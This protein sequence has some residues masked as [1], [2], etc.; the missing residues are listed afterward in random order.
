M[1]QPARRVPGAMCERKDRVPRERNHRKG[2]VMFA[3][4]LV[5]TEVPG[6]VVAVL[7][8]ALFVLPLIPEFADSLSQTLSR[9][10]QS[11]SARIHFAGTK[12]GRLPAPGRLR[13]T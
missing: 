4:T 2:Y 8:V 9:S 6:F 3:T 10:A 1:A 12:G 5:S 7:F 11:S 13:L